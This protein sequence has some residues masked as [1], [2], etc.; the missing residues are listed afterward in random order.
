VFTATK[1][2]AAEHFEI[3]AAGTRIGLPSADAANRI[4][5]HSASQCRPR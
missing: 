4:A 2:G 3:E 5:R 1:D